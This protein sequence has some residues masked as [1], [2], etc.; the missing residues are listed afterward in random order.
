MSKSRQVRDFLYQK[1]LRLRGSRIMI[2]LSSGD[3][4]KQAGDDDE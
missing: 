2:A 1:H 3:T 4:N